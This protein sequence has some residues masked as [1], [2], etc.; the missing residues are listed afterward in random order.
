MIGIDPVIEIGGLVRRTG[1][2]QRRPGF[3]D[4]NAVDLVHDGEVQLA[5]HALVQ[6]ADDQVVAEIVESVFVVRAVGNVGAIGFVPRAGA[7]MLQALIGR[8]VGRIVEKRGVVLND[9]HRESQRMIELAH[10][11]GV[12]LGQVVV[13]GDEMR[14]FAFERIQVQRQGRHQGFP[15]AGLHFRDAA[16]VENHAADQLHVEMAHVQLAPR[17]F[18]AHREGFGQDVVQG[19]AG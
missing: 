16:L 5:L 4:Q 6:I 8:I 9:S 15:F 11:L 13:D 17:H 7:K 18:T 3:V 10:P 14:A 12:A 2:D 1:D 19:F